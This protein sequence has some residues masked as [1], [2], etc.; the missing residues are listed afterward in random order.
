MKSTWQ[1]DDGT[2]RLY[3]ADCRD[4]LPEL[5]SLDVDSVVTDPP[6]GI[7]YEAH[8]YARASR[9]RKT[10]FIGYMEGDRI[11]FDP[12][13][14]LSF[15]VPTIIWGANNFAERLPRGGW[16]CWDKRTSEQ[17]DKMFGSPFELAW[18]SN[19]SKYKMLRLLHNGMFNADGANSRRFHPT[20]KPIKLMSWCLSMVPGKTILDLY[21]GSGT[22]G[23][24]CVRAGLG[25]VGVEVDE[26]YFRVA[27]ERIKKELEKPGFFKPP[28]PKV[29][30]PSLFPAAGKK[31]RIQP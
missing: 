3:R 23:V 11:D 18:H 30:P 27:V 16:L 2:I 21:M 10:T 19:P 25:F 7:S 12:G 15:G 1:T 8:R 6:Y 20:Q 4:I 14:I 31:K 17:A 22:T 13:P 26:K 29:K 24:A 5:R 28:R 9:G